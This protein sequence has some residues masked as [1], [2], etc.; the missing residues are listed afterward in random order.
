LY[1]EEAIDY[2]ILE[3]GLSYACK[4]LNIKDVP[5]F[6]LKCIQLFETTIV[7]HGKLQEKIL[8]NK[9]SSS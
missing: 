9:Y 2:K 7:R 3:E 5:G 8:L 4:Q 6:I 1:R